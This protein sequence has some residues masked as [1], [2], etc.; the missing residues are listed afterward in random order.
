MTLDANYY[1]L[2]ISGIQGH[3]RRRIEIQKQ[4]IEKIQEK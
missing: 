4:L 2:T 3:V 1:M